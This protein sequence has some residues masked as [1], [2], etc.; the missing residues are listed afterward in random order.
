MRLVLAL[1]ALLGLSACG[2]GLFETYRDTNVAISSQVNFTAG[3]YLGRWYEVGRFPVPFERNCVGAT[4]EYGKNDDGSISVFNT[5]YNADGSVRSTI[6]GR[7]DP[8]G[9]GRLKVSFPSVPFVKSDYWVLWV[10]QDYRT[11]VVGAPNGRSGWIL[12]RSPEISSD[13]LEAAKEILRANGY[14]L[15]RLELLK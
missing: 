2:G 13:R 14:D 12:N 15:S 11:A 1:T 4:A 7:A 5:C 10:D 6:V 8:V 9:P 3:K